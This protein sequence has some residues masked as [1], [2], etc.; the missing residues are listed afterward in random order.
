M[1]HSAKILVLTTEPLPLPGLPTTGAGMRAWGLGF[2][3][4]AAG[5]ENVE[6][7]FAADSVRGK[8]VESGVVAGVSTFER[9]EL[10]EF[11][12]EKRPD[13]VVLQHWGLAQDLPE[14]KC[15]LAIDLAGPHLLERRLWGS[16]DP[17]RDLAEK[18]GTLAKADF[19]VCSG[20]FQRHYFLPYLMQ[21]GFDSVPG[22]CPVI[23]FSV[24]PDIPAPMPDRDTSAFL[25]S[26]FFLPWQDPERALRWTLEVLDEREKGKLV[27]VGGP[28]PSSDVS[29]GKYD[30]LVR[31]LDEHPRAERHGT[32]PFEKLLATM[33]S[34]GASIDLM[35]RNLERELAFPT[36]TIVQ[37][38][39]GMPVIHND[40]D[41][42][43][44][45]IAR[46]KA[47]W[48]T[49][50]EDK[51]SFQKI[52]RRLCGHG[53]D[54]ASRGARAQDLVRERY[55]WDRTTG[56]LAAWCEDP[57]V[58]KDKR[59]PIVAA[60]D[61]RTNSAPGKRRANA[62][63]SAPPPHAPPNRFQQILAP[64]AFLAAIPLGAALFLVFGLAEIARAIVAGPRRR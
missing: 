36:R 40:Y 25:Y 11:V 28:H 45:P 19:T 35:P 52:V 58:R 38:W 56:P 16:R 9:T 44:D 57:R 29:G 5:F 51:K 6:M 27:V 62:P 12:A 46:A 59:R 17:Q 39:A 2:G 55:T 53:E 49:D 21:A 18:L 7:A 48:T 41:E 8:T 30:D 43:A 31:L 63:E 42:L 26:G 60:A 14:L 34:C 32:M 15:P 10:R 3:L 4:R 1:T 22:L 13:A 20:V 54:V 64:I 47:G 33:L 23:P 37:M 24:S 50:P 61:L